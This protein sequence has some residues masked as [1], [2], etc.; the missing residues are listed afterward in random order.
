MLARNGVWMSLCDLQRDGLLHNCLNSSAA[1]VSALSAPTSHQHADFSAGVDVT[2]NH[3][4]AGNFHFRVA[5]DLNVFAEF[6][7]T[8]AWRSA[9]KSGLT[10]VA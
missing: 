9:S 7:A 2:G 10:S 1:I 3:A 4:V 8:I 5:G 6:F